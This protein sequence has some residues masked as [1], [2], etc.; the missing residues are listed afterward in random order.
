M[1]GRLD[2]RP[3]IIRALAS[4]AHQLDSSLVFGL[5]LR[6]T[7]EAA[8]ADWD[9]LRHA[10]DSIFALVG[11]RFGAELGEGDGEVTVASFVPR[12]TQ[13]L[14]SMAAELQRRAEA[15]RGPSLRQSSELMPADAEFDAR[16]GVDVTMTGA[17]VPA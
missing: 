13:L 2:F 9:E 14:P 6:P 7:D 11:G 12:V 3:E 8:S 1:P 15:A 10:F 16:D 4:V 5:P 17:F